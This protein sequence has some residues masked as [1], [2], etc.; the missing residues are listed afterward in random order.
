MKTNLLK[1]IRN[2]RGMATLEAIP[3]IFVFM[4][5]LTYELGMFGVIHTGIMNSI[6]SRA[7][8]F[9]TFRNRSNLVYFRDTG[10]P[11]NVLSEFRTTGNRTHSVASERRSDSDTNRMGVA[12]ER[13]IRVGG[14]AVESITSTRNDGVTHNTKVFDQALVGQQKRNQLVEVSPVWIQVQYGICINAKCE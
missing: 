8:A 7:Y 9:E 12:T 11:G 5:L 6:S 4:L 10:V 3:L 2:E 13:P 14:P 1:P